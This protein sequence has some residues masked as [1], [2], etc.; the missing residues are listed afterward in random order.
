MKRKL[1]RKDDNIDIPGILGILI[2][3]CFSYG[4]VNTIKWSTFN[5]K[6][7]AINDF[8]L[9]L[10]KIE[11]VNTFPEKPVFGVPLSVAVERSMCHDGIELPVI[12][13]ECID[14]V[15]ENGK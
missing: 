7:F 9:K 4:S 1:K 13:R 15:E 10:L 14:F 2:D 5:L 12:V 8:C 6:Y 11:M 3:K